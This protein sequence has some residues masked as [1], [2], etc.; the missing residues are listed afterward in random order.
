MAEVYS[1]R[2]NLCTATRPGLGFK[3]AAASRAVSSC[4]VTS[5]YVA[6]SGRGIP[7]GG[8][9][10]VRNLRA[11]FS[12]SSACSPALPRSSI[13][14]QSGGLEFSVVAGYAVLIQHGARLRRRLLRVGRKV[15]V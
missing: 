5:A 6:L 14:R 15:R 4:L 2:F 1:D 12:H 8:I 3:A 10:P 9:S 11:T 7:G 13:Q